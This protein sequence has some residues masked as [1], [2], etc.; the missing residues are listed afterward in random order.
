MRSKKFLKNSFISVFAQGIIV[1]LQ[2]LTRRVFV[3]YMN[4][5]LL[6][7][8]SLFSNIFNLV[9][10][11]EM[12][13]GNVIV[14]NLYREIAENNIDNIRKYVNIYKILY[15]CVACVIAILGIIC[16]PF[17]PYLINGIS[18]ERLEYI[19]KI[20]LLQLFGVVS[21]YFLSYL[22]TIFI[23]DQKEYKCV[24]CD[25]I[26]RIAIQVIQI[27]VLV[28]T[29]NFML[30]LATKVIINIIINL[31][32]CFISRK[33]YPYLK[34]KYPVSFNAI[35]EANIFKDTKDFMVHKLANIVYGGTDN[36][37]ISS[38]LGARATALF[39]NY[40]TVQNSV[41]NMFLYKAI[42]PLRA[43]IGNLIY[44]DKTDNEQ[45]DLFDMFNLIGFFMA[46]FVAVSF[47]VLYQPFI[48]LWLGEDYLLPFSFVIAQAVV[49]YFQINFEIIYMYRSAFGEFYRDKKYMVLSAIVNLVLSF[50]MASKWGIIGVVGGTFLGLIIIIYGRLRFVFLKY[51]S[52]NL[53]QYLILQ[54]KMLVLF[55]IECVAVCCIT[56]YIPYGIAGFIGKGIICVVVTNGLNVLVFYRSKPFKKL[57]SYFTKNI[58]GQI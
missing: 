20:Y 2:F 24:I 57:L 9:S 26:G 6:G 16:I 21:G 40:Y 12:G 23:A 34:T 54:I 52:F 11:A 13:I 27:L 35:V 44:S 41:I 4:I 55:G 25:L 8:E 15:R 1:L 39:G 33:D 5:E 50:F 7:Y 29:S 43:S 19:R 46:D 56:N 36:I 3:K 51:P 49:V 32:V 47:L 17:I 22:R 38:L 53:K 18:I 48:T 42:N 58:G 14:F 10:M 31:M 30:Y 28:L 45:K 37:V